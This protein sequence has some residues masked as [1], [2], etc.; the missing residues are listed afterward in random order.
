MAVKRTL[1]PMRLGSFIV[2]AL[3]LSLPPGLSL[4]AEWQWSVAVEG[5][6]S[7]ETH[8]PPRAFLWI[9]PDC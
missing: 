2:P 4:A 5:V 3:S 9:P 6:T 1:S 7:P 8:A